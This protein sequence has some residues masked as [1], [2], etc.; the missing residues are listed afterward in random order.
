MPSIIPTVGRKVWYF[1]NTDKQ[2]DPW[3]ATVIKIAR[4]EPDENGCRPPDDS[5]TPVNLLVTNPD[6]GG[7]L[8]EPGVV[9]GDENTT[10]RHYRWMPYQRQQAEKAGSQ[11]IG[12]PPAS[13]PVDSGETST[14][15]PIDPANTAKPEDP[16]P[17]FAGDERTAESATA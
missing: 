4:P 16:A 7:Q 3:D 13:G 1:S 6:T 5:H 12:I 11:P 15:T 9:A 2:T 8:F 14:G 17:A 10:G